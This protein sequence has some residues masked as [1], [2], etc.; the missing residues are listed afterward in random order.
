MENNKNNERINRI[1]NNLHVKTAYRNKYKKSCIS[2]RMKELHTPGIS[3]TV[4]DK[5]RIAWTKGFGVKEY[6]NTESVNNDTMFL[7]GSISKPVFA[8]AVMKLKE[9]GI[10]DLDTD[11]N[12]YLKRWKIPKVNYW[13]PKI[14]LRQIL[15]HTAGL[16]IHG[17]EGYLQTEKL[18]STPQIL[19]GEYPANTKE[20]VVNTLPGIKYRYS[21]GGTTIAQLAVEDLL[22]KPFP[23]IMNEELFQ[24][25]KIENST[26]E[27]YLPSSRLNQIATGYFEKNQEVNGGHYVYPEMVAAG[28]WTTSNDLAKIIIEIQNALKGKSDYLKRETV[29]EMLTPQKIAPFMGISFFLDGTNNER[30]S[31]TGC[32]HGFVAHLISYKNDSKGAVILVNSNEGTPIIEEIFMAI[33]EEYNW[34]DYFP[35][36]RNNV[37]I[38]SKMINQYIGDYKSDSDI[39]IKIFSEKQTLYLKVN[40][41]DP[42]VLSS[43]DSENFYI[44]ILNTNIKFKITK[45]KEVKGLTI[46]QDGV[47]IDAKKL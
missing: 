5:G 41:Q 10:I 44:D 28:L 13:Q 6:G 14:T 33:A 21:G 39:K 9:K 8:L 12:N 37:K 1:I 31:H 46:I 16:T 15:S 22:G 18:P 40:K 47:R 2:T 27:Q 42:I 34:I 32:D 7:A 3:I 19:S 23:Q 25:L 20:V 4:I 24:P 35:K 11:I 29:E 30:F 17:F 38:N 26:Y 43:V 36:E 45:E